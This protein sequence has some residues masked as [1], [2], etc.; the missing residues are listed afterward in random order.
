MRR[1]MLFAEEGKGEERLSLFLLLDGSLFLV[2][3]H[4]FIPI[5]LAASFGER[6][7]VKWATN[8]SKKRRRL[9]KRKKRATM[10]TQKLRDLMH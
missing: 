10:S 8:S 9:L 1:S 5:H 2:E 3:L 7:H 4:N 6:H